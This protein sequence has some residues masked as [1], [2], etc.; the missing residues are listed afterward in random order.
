MLVAG[1]DDSSIGENDIGVCANG[2][3]SRIFDLQFSD[4]DSGLQLIVNKFNTSSNSCRERHN[5]TSN[6]VIFFFFFSNN[7]HSYPLASNVVHGY[8]VGNS[9]VK[10]VQ[11]FVYLGG[12]ICSNAT[13]DKD[14][15]QKK[16]A[17]V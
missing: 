10:Q 5:R 4:S 13:C 16:L 12:T 7:A 9:K 6:I 11:E 8:Q 1:C 14:I 2:S 15:S 3:S 17:L